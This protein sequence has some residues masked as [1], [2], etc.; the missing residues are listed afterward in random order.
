MFKRKTFLVMGILLIVGLNLTSCHFPQ[1]SSEASFVTITET[2]PLST[3]TLEPPPPATST[4]TATFTPTPTV[5]TTTPTQTPTPVWVYHEPGEV[6]APILLYHHIDGDSFDNRYQVT[7]PNFRSQMEWLFEHGYTAIT[8]STLVEVLLEGGELPEKP[9]VITFDDGHLSVFENAF[10]IMDELGFPGVF[11][12][13]A[14]RIYDSPGFV[15]SE[16]I[17]TM[18]NAGWEVG[19]HGYSHQDITQNHYSAEHEIAQSKYDLQAALDVPVNTFAYP[20]GLIDP[21]TATMVSNAGYKAGMGLGQSITHTWGNL[22]YLHRIEV[23][24][25][26]TLEMFTARLNPVQ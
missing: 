18:L 13:V 24:G 4:P 11:Y 20:Y 1:T 2:P 6:V 22:F 23:Y 25:S 19:S 21:Y 7:I 3:P 10:P 14:N 5:P 8:I 12:I 9:I 26:D 17:K 16:Q 15:T